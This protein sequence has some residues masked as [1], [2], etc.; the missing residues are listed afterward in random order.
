MSYFS[1]YTKNSQERQFNYDGSDFSKS[2]DNTLI[3][4]KNYY[5]QGNTD[6]NIGCIRIDKADN[7]LSFSSLENNTCIHTSTNASKF[8]L[9][10]D[11]FNNFIAIYYTDGVKRYYLYDTTANANKYQDSRPKAIKFEQ[12]II[13]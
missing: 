8:K 3:C 1:R 11:I 7:K 13:K 4:T 10:F 9:E 6:Y 2:A 12:I 5:S